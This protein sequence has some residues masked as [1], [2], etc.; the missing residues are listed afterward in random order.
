MLDKI[1]KS[2]IIKKSF[3]EIDEFDKGPEIYLIMGIVL[4]MQLK[5]LQILKFLME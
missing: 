2:L 5:E 4:V 1:Y 3:I